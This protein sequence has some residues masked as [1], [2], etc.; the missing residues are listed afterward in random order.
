MKFPDMNQY[1][2]L[3][4]SLLAEFLATQNPPRRR[5]RQRRYTDASWLVFHA[6]MA[7]KGIPALRAQQPWRVQ[8]L[9]MRARFRSIFQLGGV[10]LCL[11]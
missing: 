2:I 9:R 8:H 11:E 5:G 3:L 1:I 10:E 7:L 4:F 6:A